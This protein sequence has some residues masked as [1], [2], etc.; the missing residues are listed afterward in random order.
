MILDTKMN[1]EDKCIEE[2]TPIQYSTIN[3]PDCTPNFALM[4][5][6]FDLEDHPDFKSN[7]KI[8]KLKLYKW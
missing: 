8:N 4:Q 3:T 7:I 2:M 5:W 1:L 6:K